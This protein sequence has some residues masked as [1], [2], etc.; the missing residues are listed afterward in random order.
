MWLTSLVEAPDWQ[1]EDRAK[2]LKDAEE[3]VKFL[4]DP[5]VKAFKPY[6]DEFET[7]RRKGETL[8]TGNKVLAKECSLCGYRH[9]CWPDAQLHAR[10]TSQAKSPPQVWYTRLKTKEL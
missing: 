6:P 7:Y 5:D 9:H 1:D 2:Y 10:V 8:R 4:T 3:R